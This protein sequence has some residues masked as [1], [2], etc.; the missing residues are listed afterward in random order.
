VAALA[1]VIGL[2]VGLLMLSSAVHSVSVMP[3]LSNGGETRLAWE[4][5]RPMIT[6]ENAVGERVRVS[7]DEYFRLIWTEREA[8]GFWQKFM[9]K[10]FNVSS[11]GSMLF[12]GIGLAGQLLFAGRLVVQWLATERSRRSVVPTAFWWMALGGATMLIVY[13]GW[14]KDVVGVLGQSTGWIIYIRNLYF[15]YFKAPVGEMASSAGDGEA[16]GA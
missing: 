1:V 4:D 6:Y 7:P 12:V 10:L 14:R 8:M 16:T 11:P 9:M 3:E 5:Q 13:F 2:G 15:I